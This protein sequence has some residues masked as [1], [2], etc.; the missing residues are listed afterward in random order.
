MWIKQVLKRSNPFLALYGIFLL[1]GGYILLSF[2][3]EQLHLQINSLHNNFFDTFFKYYTHTGD[4]VFIIVVAVLLLFVKF[5]Y[6][7]LLTLSGSLTG[8]VTQFLK[9]IVF[10]NSMR[11]GAYF[12]NKEFL[13]TIPGVELNNFFSF[14]SGHTSGGFCLFFVLALISKNNL[15]STL[16]FFLALLTGFSRVYLSQHF[17]DDIYAGSAVGVFITFFI[18]AIMD[19]H[20]EL[21]Q[22]NWMEKSLIRK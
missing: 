9:H 14:P 3:K 15:W 22:K 2:E 6:A 11:P 13:Y 21:F 1:V 17:F 8:L 20:K 12:E 16:F 4:G 7:I 19:W 5:R 10:D 18:F